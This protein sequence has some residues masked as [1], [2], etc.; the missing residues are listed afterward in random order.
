[1]P[2]TTARP[3]AVTTALL[4]LLAAIFLSNCR[5]SESPVK[6]STPGKKTVQTIPAPQSSVAPGNLI[7]SPEIALKVPDL[8]APDDTVPLPS[9]S[10][11]EDTRHPSAETKRPR[12][13]IIIDDMGYHQQ[14]GRQFLQLNLNLTYSFLPDAPYSGELAATAYQSGRDILVHLPMEPKDAAK[15]PGADG[16]SVQDTPELIRQKMARM[17]S[18][19]PHAVGA[20][21]HMG[22][23]FTE[24]SGAMQVVIDTLKNRSLF[25]IDSYTTAASRGLTIARQQGVP[26]APRHVFLDTVQEPQQICRQIEQLLA[27]AKKRGWAIGIG[28]P[29]EATLIALTQYNRERFLDVEFVGA[30][31]LVE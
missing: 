7:I 20:N 16:L 15:H 10:L 31:Q 1:V 4:F 17:L 28:H 24:D 5:S 18:A 3:S 12:I 11:R 9:P 25:F 23:R 29:N 26:T 30:H 8:P 22:S 27:G 2:R 14:L 19:V 21:N 13:A 6:K